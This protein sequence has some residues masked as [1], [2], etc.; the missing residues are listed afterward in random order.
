MNKLNQIGLQKTDSKEIADKLNEL[1]ANYHLYYQ[2]LRGFHWNIKGVH[3]FQLHAKFE[4]LYNAALTKIDE[5]AERILTIGQTPLHTFSD[6]VRVAS[7]K[8]AGSLSGDTETVR[9]THENLTVLLNLEREILILA[10]ETGDEGT[11]GLISEDINE[12]EKTLWMLNA[13]LS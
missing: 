8:E 5:I 9:A 12:N 2:N 7:I 11:V 13:F 6:Y 4:E 3:F 1:L 10:A